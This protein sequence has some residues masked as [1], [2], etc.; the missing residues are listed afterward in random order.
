MVKTLALVVLLSGSP[1][2]PPLT[3][4]LPVGN[5]ADRAQI[6]GKP[7]TNTHRNESQA[8]IHNSGNASESSTGGR[9]IQT[10]ISRISRDVDGFCEV[11]SRMQ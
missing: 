4:V 5:A 1:L 8:R 7:D 9:S 2:S 10:M 6:A 11:V 3:T